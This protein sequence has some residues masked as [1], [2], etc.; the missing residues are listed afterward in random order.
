[1]NETYVTISG[2]VVGDPVARATKANVPFVTFR[3]ASNVRRVDFKTGEYIDAGTN[4]VNVT[5]F[6]SLGVNL[7]NSLKKGEP[8]IVYGRMRINQ[9]VNGERSGTTVEID[10]YNVGHDLSWGQTKFVKVAKPQLNQ[11]DRMADPEVQDA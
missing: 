10:A 3:V 6:R 2:N 1:M 4:F 5:A 8:V 7:A 9:W 11:N